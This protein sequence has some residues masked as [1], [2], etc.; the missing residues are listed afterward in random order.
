VTDDVLRS[1]AVSHHLLGVD[2]F[3]VVGHTDCGLMTFRD[4][5]LRARIRQRWGR[6]EPAGDVRRVFATWKRTSAPRFAVFA[7]R[8]VPARA[9]VRGFVYELRTGRLNEVA[10]ARRHPGASRIFGCPRRPDPTARVGG[11]LVREGLQKVASARPRL[12]RA[13]TASGARWKRWN[14]TRPRC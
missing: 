13:R 4:A 10:A 3:I 1:L 5:D 9:S 14:K 11:R 12:R 6:R 8:F 7:R 2:K